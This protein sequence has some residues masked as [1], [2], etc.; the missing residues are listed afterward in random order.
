MKERLPQ[1]QAWIP[2]AVL[3][4][5][6]AA[7]VTTLPDLDPSSALSTF[8]PC[9]TLEGKASRSLGSEVTA[10]DDLTSSTTD[11]PGDSSTT[12]TTDPDEDTTTT[13]DPDTTTTDPGGSTSTTSTT[14][15]AT[16]STTTIDPGGFPTITAD[17]DDSTTTSTDPDDTTTTSTDP[18]DTTTTTSDADDTT[19]T[20]TDPDDTT[21]ST[22][23]PDGSTTTT[24]DPGGPTTSTT[25]PDDTTTTTTDPDDTTT[26]TTDSC[27]P[28]TTEDQGTTTTRQGGGG[29]TLSFL[30]RNKEAI[31]ELRVGYWDDAF[32]AAGKLKAN[33][34]NTDFRRFHLRVVDADAN[35][36]KVRQKVEVRVATDSADNAYDDGPVTLDLLETGTDT[37]RFDSEALLLVS[38][39]VDDKQATDAKV[40][41]NQRNDRSFLV[42]LG[43]SVTASYKRTSASMAVPVHDLIKLHITALTDNTME[44]L[45]LAGEPFLDALPYNRM[46]DD[47]KDGTPAELFRDVDGNGRY[48]ARLTQKQLEKR[49]LEDIRY[50]NEVY[51]HAAIRLVPVDPA[52]PVEYKVSDGKL[53]MGEVAVTGGR[54]GATTFTDHERE[55]HGKNWNSV[56]ADDVEVYLVSTIRYVDNRGIDVP[57]TSTAGFS[58]LASAYPF[59]TNKQFNDSLVLS[60][61]DPLF[62]LAHEIY[63]VVAQNPAHDGNL[64]NLMRPHPQQFPMLPS[65]QRVTDSR[66]L[67]VSQILKVNRKYLTKP[68]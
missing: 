32:D 28:E 36:P 1:R 31:P 16:T 55:L 52:R 68:K 3:S 6:L 33:F 9:T 62:V 51:A 49:V 7:V 56:A 19:T 2:L 57:N 15:D 24:T 4:L 61:V 14:S 46:Y 21:T 59:A 50:T 10:A 41:D 45:P 8:P 64:V 48:T 18:G 22:S 67:T 13:T 29:P 34:V 65:G 54:P 60:N 44:K 37:G 20:S 11:L 23:D 43:A 12:T 58:F 17:P 27:S 40:A 39:E 30:D 26:T 38:N 35:D 5:V 25:D 66:R 47:R 63:H 42:A 53:A